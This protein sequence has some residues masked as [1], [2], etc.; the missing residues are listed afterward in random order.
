MA[1]IAGLA[2]FVL[3]LAVILFFKKTRELTKTVRDMENR[4]LSLES[5]AGRSGSGADPASPGLSRAAADPASPEVPEGLPRAAADPA[6][7]EVPEGLPAAAADPASPGGL[8]GSLL[9][10]IHG[11]NLWAAGGVILLTAGFAMLVSHMARRGFFTVEMGIAA[12]ALAGMVMLGLGWRFR[13][14]R[15]VYFLI[16]QGGGIGILYLSVFAAHKLTPY[17]PAAASIILMSLLIPPALVLAFLQ[18][19]QSL[20]V[21]GFF[22]GFAAPVLIGSGGGQVFLFSYYAV[23]D[24]GVLVIAYFKFWRALNLLAFFCTFG[25]ALFWVMGGYTPALFWTCEPF[26]FGFIL[27]FTLLGIC[28]AS[29]LKSQ[30]IAD[31]AILYPA[32]SESAPDNRDFCATGGAKIHGCDRLPEVHAAGERKA[33]WYFDMPLILGTPMAGA[34]LQWKI[35]SYIPHGYALACILFSAIYLVLA[36]VLRRRNMRIFA[37]AYLGFSILLANLILPLELSGRVSGAV[38]AAEGVL[39]FYLGLR[40]NRIRVLAAG[41]ILHIAAA[42]ALGLEKRSGLYLPFRSPA[43]IDSLIISLSAMVIIILAHTQ[44]PQQARVPGAFYPANSEGAP[45]NRDFSATGGAK[46]HKCSRLP[47]AALW[48]F[49]WWF[50]G[51]ALECGRA[52]DRPWEVFFIFASAT[53]LASFAGAAKFRAPVLRVGGVPVLGLALILSLGPLFRRFAYYLQGYLVYDPA[54]VF[55]YNFFTGLYRWGWPAFFAVQGGLLFFSRKNLRP[56]I[57][58]P[59]LF[60][61]ILSAL[62]VFTASGRA[63]TGQ[64]GLPESWTAL[65]G[66]LP[67]L[68]ATLVL[69]FLCPRFSGASPGFHRGLIFFVLPLTLNIAA[70]LWFA[71]TLF[72]PGNPAPLPR[73]M[74][75]IN[76][77][78]LEQ[79]LCAA[80][81]LVWQFRA[82]RIPGLPVLS[83]GALFAL[84]DGMAFLWITALIARGVHFYQGV[85]FGRVFD[86]DIFHLCL[87]I[88]WAFWGI[89]HIIGGHR[90]LRRRAWIAGAVLT[91]LDVAK[92]LIHDLANTGAVPRIVS[93]FI[94]GLILLFIG[95][96]APLPPAVREKNGGELI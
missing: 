60:T 62:L 53:A 45:D 77:L 96:A 35:F 2:F 70:G 32:G 66:I 34:A 41:L 49:S 13:R 83:A 87:F 76:P 29:R 95:W 64:A 55:T 38:W 14:R 3:L 4:L 24:M 51:W 90:F 63:F 61:V 52:L 48:A 25:P 23:L 59:W 42:L 46:I 40:Q 79:A 56:S 69:A 84:G 19:S 78:D 27:I 5:L 9:A 80:A 47:G 92:L 1:L 20:A 15:P 81:I 6:S 12:S 93:F 50:C 68:T 36:L 71:V 17:F 44:K 30:R 91:V 58:A 28:R 94:A 74:P 85:P 39:I 82:R 18:G 67:M 65:A 8:W 31:Q 37:E 54:S 43:F 88:F 16:L 11:G 89:T 33:G 7:P 86:S 57:H 26:L 21:L 75:V 73:Y 22:G 72:L 10:F